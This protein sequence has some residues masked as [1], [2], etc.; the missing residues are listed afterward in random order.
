MSKVPGGAHPGPT[1]YMAILPPATLIWAVPVVAASRIN[2]P[3]RLIFKIFRRLATTNF[4]D[5]KWTAD[6]DGVARANTVIIAADH[7]TDM[8]ADQ[9][10][11]AIAEARFL[12]GHFH[13]DAKMMW[14]NV[15][16][17]DETVYKLQSTFQY[18]GYMATD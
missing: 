13:F 10:N 18:G 4:L 7:A 15:P 9:K 16:Y 12:R 1:G 5:D 2:R 8:S 17:V 11:E 14:N 3:M 6:Y